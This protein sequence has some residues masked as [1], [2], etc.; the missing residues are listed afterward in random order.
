MRSWLSARNV[1]FVARGTLQLNRNVVVLQ[2]CLPADLIA[3][4]ESDLSEERDLLG[5]F[6]W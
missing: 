3:I 1:S 5:L 4:L 2:K 6:F